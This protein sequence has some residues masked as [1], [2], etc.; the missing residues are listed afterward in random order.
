MCNAIARVCSLTVFYIN[1]RY[2]IRHLFTIDE[3]VS[4]LTAW[5]FMWSNNNNYN[6]DNYKKCHLKL[7]MQ[8]SWAQLIDMK[9][10]QLNEGLTMC[11]HQR[12][13]NKQTEINSK[14]HVISNSKR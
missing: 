13:M 2:G 1:K 9:T 6:S 7:Y 3:W 11:V 12:K 4:F 5:P 10:T 8:F 14:H